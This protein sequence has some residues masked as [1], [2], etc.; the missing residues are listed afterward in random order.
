MADE[1]YRA[2]NYGRYGSDRQRRPSH[3]EADG[4]S[5]HYRSSGAQRDAADDGRPTPSDRY[6]SGRPRTQPMN[7]DDALPAPRYS[8]GG[9]SARATYGRTGDARHGQQQDAYRRDGEREQSIYTPRPEQGRMGASSYARDSWNGAEDR[10]AQGQHRQADRRAHYGGASFEQP[11]DRDG[12][13]A[14]RGQGYG[15][16]AP[17]Q[18]ARAHAG[19]Q[20]RRDMRDQGRATHARQQAPAGVELPEPLARALDVLQANPVLIAAAAAG[21]ALIV[22]IALIA[23][24]VAGN[25]Q[26]GYVQAVSSQGSDSTTSTAT[27]VSASA[28][29]TDTAATGTGSA[30]GAATPA[31]TD[32]AATG[33]TA[34]QQADPA[35]QT[36]HDVDDVTAVSD[37]WAYSTT[38]FN[39]DAAY[40][41]GGVEDPWSPTGY[42]TTGDAELDQMVKSYCDGQAQDGLDAGDNAYYTYL[43][44]SWI[45]YVENDN[46]QRPWD[47]EGDWRVTY[48]KQCFTNMTANCYEFAAAIQYIMRYYGYADAIAEP[49]LVLKQSGAWGDHGLVFLTSLDG[50]QCLIDASLSSNGWL[51]PAASMTYKLD[52]GY[53]AG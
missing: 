22:V 15:G 8:E 21:V 1:R 32:T 7:H 41:N 34:Q 26:Q 38:S 33:D 40:N 6:P 49:C 37:V 27:D 2:D 4:A 48:A 23:S 18:G 50:R 31:S 12:R 45:D 42:F 52:S 20:G 25:S 17:E 53:R 44:I 5:G 51:L 19:A 16:P 14:D 3:R 46:N 24:C 11:R 43:H 28:T 35:D 47:V 10:P 13:R 29:P 39:K 9:Y 36:P 30:D